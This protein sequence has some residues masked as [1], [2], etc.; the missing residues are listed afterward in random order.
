VKIPERFTTALADLSRHDYTDL[1]RRTQQNLPGIRAQSFDGPQVSSG[2]GPSDPTGSGALQRED[3]S[4]QMRKDFVRALAQ[5]E[6]ARNAL[7]HLAATTTPPKPGSRDW[8][9]QTN[10]PDCQ[11]C[12]EA[13]RPREMVHTR[14][15]FATIEGDGLPLP[16]EYPVCLAHYN[17]IR[18]VERR[19]TAAEDEHFTRYGKW[20]RGDRTEVTA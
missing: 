9:E 11:L 2:Q 20:P 5:L 17:H 12:R 6:Q 19:T 15:R 13:G 1:D 16:A 14:T 8:F 3:R 4:V 18:R 10:E 7:D